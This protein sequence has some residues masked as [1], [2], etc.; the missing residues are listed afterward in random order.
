[1]HILI[2]GGGGG[3]EGPIANVGLFIKSWQMKKKGRARGDQLQYVNV[4]GPFWRE[5]FSLYEVE[6]CKES[7][8]TAA[9]NFEFS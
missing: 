9:L 5:L 6:L 8:R 3:I 7:Y 2:C 4:K 1:M